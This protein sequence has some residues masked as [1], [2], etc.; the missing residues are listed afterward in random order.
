MLLYNARDAVS[1][2][3]VIVVYIILGSIFVPNNKH[4]ACCVEPGKR[5]GGFILDRATYL[6]SH[7]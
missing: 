6:K 4:V 1:P 7:W 5:L 3:V 2:R